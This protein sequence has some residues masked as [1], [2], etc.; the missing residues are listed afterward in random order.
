MGDTF[1]IYNP[2]SQ[3]LPPSRKIEIRGHFSPVFCHCTV[4]EV[5]VYSVCIQKSME[6]GIPF[7]SILP[8]KG[9]RSFWT[10]VQKGAGLWSS[11]QRLTGDP[12]FP[13]IDKRL[14]QQYAFLKGQS[15]GTFDL[16]FV[17][18]S[19]W[20]GQQVTIFRQEL[21]PKKT[22]ENFAKIE[23]CLTHW[24]VAQAGSKNEKKNWRSKILLDCPFTNMDSVDCTDCFSS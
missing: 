3:F 24:S 4:S 15:N 8:I 2:H 7:I 23:I 20:P 16:Q 6:N 9:G 1:Y 22:R 18:N 10:M 17:H 5:E 14:I 21:E 12:V 19:K 13:E 11:V